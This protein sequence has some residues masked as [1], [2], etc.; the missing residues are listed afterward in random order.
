MPILEIMLTVRETICKIN[1]GYDIMKIWLCC[2]ILRNF[3]VCFKSAPYFMHAVYIAD[4]L[5]LIKLT[6]ELVC[7]MV[8][9][10]RWKSKETFLYLTLWMGGVNEWYAISHN[11]YKWSHTVFT[12]SCAHYGIQTTKFFYRKKIFHA[13]KS[14]FHLLFWFKNFATHSLKKF[15]R[16]NI[17]VLLARPFRTSFPSARC[18]PSCVVLA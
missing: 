16:H 18:T 6:L 12:M 17:N 5:Q 4:I 10:S 1:V 7:G 13:N 2:F 8:H 3:W 9:L 14:D 15:L 11:K